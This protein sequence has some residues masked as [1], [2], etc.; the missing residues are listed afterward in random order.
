[1]FSITADAQHNL[2]I[3]TGNW[4]STNSLYLNPANIADSRERFTID[5]VSINASIENNLG[6]LGSFSNFSKAVN[7]GNTDN[8][9]NYSNRNT[10][11]LLAPAVDIH[12]PGAMIS[13]NHKH[14]LALTTRIRGFNQ[15][16][17]FDKSL[18]RTIN[19]PNYVINGDVDLTSKNFNYTAHLW[20]EVGL[21]YGVVLID[22]GESELRAG[23]TL[24]YLG[25]IGY[26]GLKGNNLD[27][28]F[29]SGTDS[30]YVKNTDLEFASNILSTK[31]ALVNGISNNSI[32]SEF[33]G[34][35]DGRG[36][37]GDI[38][39]VYDYFPDPE[40]HKHNHDGR[41]GYKVRLSAS[42]TDIGSVMYKS[43]VNSNANVTGNG[44][45][46]GQGLIDNVTN[47]D[48]FRN[49][50]KKQGFTADT[51]KAST[52]VYMP[53]A[54]VIGADYNIRKN[55]YVN[56]TFIGNVANRQ[57]FG[58]SYY[59]Q[60]TVTP[61]Y[62]RRLFTIG[63]PITY[64]MLTNGMRMGLGLRFMGLFAGS[65]DMLTLFAK[66]QYGFNLYF[67][68]CVP[69]YHKS[70][71]HYWY[72][73]DSD[74]TDLSPEPDMEHGGSLDSSDN[75]PDLVLAPLNNP[76]PAVIEIQQGHTT[77]TD[78]DGIPDDEDACPTIAG[79]AS[80]HGCPLSPQPPKKTANFS[81]TTIQTGN[82]KSAIN[83]ESVK[84]LDLLA[85]ILKEYPDCNIVINGYSD[86]ANTAAK[87]IA[88]S[89]ARALSVKNYFVSK[90]IASARIKVNGLGSAQPVADNSTAEGRAK[91][92]RVVM[93]LKK[94]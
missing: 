5:V 31:N 93:N 75:C 53:T 29:R 50:A 89:K 60:V 64:S 34:N 11:S 15:F 28:H 37:G 13:I 48:E 18:Y 55:I 9:F 68:G 43:S 82:G 33:F 3:A 23:V 14:S 81:T 32:F 51:A 24:R 70:K 91:N 39:V 77:D 4:S 74:S 49:Y 26:V 88:L 45:I 35:K 30:F 47:F 36:V 46:T 66:N 22:E 65:D 6:T 54:L 61:R 56:A 8:L 41:N 57:N 25:G 20:T 76:A 58:N 59:N 62:D 27:A 94:R 63:V 73:E 90:G 44:Y 80:N 79:P 84:E 21:T 1:M 12:G 69:L 38:G 19:D 87:S 92:C 85:K 52:K 83:K 10:F 78:G 40:L 42:V 72:H 7:N 71:G 17:N 67:G 2:G 16:N 86:N